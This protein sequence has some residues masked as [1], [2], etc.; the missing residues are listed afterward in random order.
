MEDILKKN[1]LFI[2]IYLII[3]LVNIKINSQ[4]THN[5]VTAS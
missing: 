2:I 1:E 3:T 5:L 4:L